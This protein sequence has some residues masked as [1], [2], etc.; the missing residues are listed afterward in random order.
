MA[1]DVEE[2]PLK[3]AAEATGALPV[4][5]DVADAASVEAGFARALAAVGRRDGV[6]D[7][8]G[9]TRGHFPWKMPLGD[10]EL[11]RKV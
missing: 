9:L 4:G 11:V 8:A 1:C 6:V 10:W 7:D 3:E 5:M 2:G